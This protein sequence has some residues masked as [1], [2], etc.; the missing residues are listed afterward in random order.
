MDADFISRLYM[1]FTVVIVLAICTLA[2]SYFSSWPSDRKAMENEAA[3]YRRCD[4]KLTGG[5]TPFAISG[6]VKDG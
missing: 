6:G 1:I 5:R 2:F 4:Q 3:A